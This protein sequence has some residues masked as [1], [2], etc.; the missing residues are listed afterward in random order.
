MPLYWKRNP[1]LIFLATL[2]LCAAVLIGRNV[3]ERD[4]GARTGDAAAPPAPV[5]LSSASVIARLQERVRQNPDAVGAYSGL[6]LAL[7]Q[8]VRETGDPLLYA[9]AEAALNEA[10]KRNAQDF[11]ALLGQGS[12]AL[13]R[14]QFRDAL[15]WG[16]R[17]RAFNPY[18]AQPHGI[19]GDAQVEL[20]NYEA[21]A[22]SIQAMV[23]TRPDL[24]SYSRVSY[25]R[26]LHGDIPGAIIAMRQAVSAGDPRSE[27]ARWSQVQ[28]GNLAF[29]SGDLRQAEAD[30]RV[31]LAA[32]PDYPFAL[33]GLARVQAAM[34]QQDAAIQTYEGIAQR[35]PLPE[36]VIALGELYDATGQADKARRQYELVRAMQQLNASV[37]FAVDLDLARFE[38]DH[39]G[40]PAE[41][42][43]RARAA[44]A[45]QPSIFAADGMA[46]AL[47][48][49]GAYQEAQRYSEE[50]LRLGTRDALLYYHA[51]MIA[52]ALGDKAS[53]R[54]YLE[55]AMRINPYF[56]VRYVPVVEKLLRSGE[57]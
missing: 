2:V 26:E 54:Q 5:D 6:G 32:Q 17:A 52:L 40:V 7:L 51:G 33:A 50:A 20:G 10:L 57:L 27:Q 42:L 16:E 48:Y 56:S 12:L 14:H 1:E 35:L 46:W 19:I 24:N 41:A 31:A 22:A 47:Y 11:E 55:Q 34:G 13:S 25:Q 3:R 9:Q 18:S 4:A 53:A 29:N 21:A 49:T 28:L 38:P 30:Y 39:G 43:A 45:E 23:D 8:R 44:Y 15:R 36:F 37:G